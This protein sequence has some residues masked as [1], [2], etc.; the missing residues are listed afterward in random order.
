MAPRLSFSQYFLIVLTVVVAVCV[1]QRPPELSSKLKEWRKSG[2][3]FNYRGNAVFYRDDQGSSKHQ[4]SVVLCIHGFPTSSIDWSKI[5]PK[6]KEKFGRVIAVD[7]LGLGFSDKPTE[8]AYTVM[9]QADL[10]ED[11]LDHLSVRN[12][13]ILTH[14]LGDT[15]AQ[16]ML[17]RY[18][19]RM[20][21]KEEDGVLGIVTLCL[22]NGGIF[23]ETNYPR[24]TQKLLVLPWFGP[25]LARFM[26]YYLFSRSFSSI[27]DVATQPTTEELQDFWAVVAH[28]EGHLVVAK[29]L[30]YMEQRRKNRER[31]VKVLNTTSVPVHL[32]YGSS[33]PV[34]PPQMLQRYR[35]IVPRGTFTRH[36]GVGHYPHW[37]DPVGFA[38][39]YLDF[40]SLYKA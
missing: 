32:I 18:E 20:D 16:E 26:N 19:D 38:N 39:S 28:K 12:V 23:P 4:D 24:L 40:V 1:N 33:D 29:I 15:V 21:D 6:L 14:D 34:N 10:L 31:W 30:D 8:H 3:Y 22:S 27:F 17:A 9:D 7:M 13:H 25:F 35:E 5:W 36:Q 37:E 11:L 2:R